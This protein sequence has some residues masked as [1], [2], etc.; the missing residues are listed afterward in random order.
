MFKSGFIGIIGRPNVGKSTL[1]NA[2][3]GEK[4]AIATHKPQTTRNRITGILNIEQGQLV[5]VDTPGIHKAST[6]LNQQMVATAT[7]TFKHADI[8]C[9]LMEADTGLQRDDRLIIDSLKQTGLPIVLVINKIDLI[10]KTKLLPLIDEMRQY[11]DFEAIIPIS[12]LTKDGISD[13]IGELWK[14]LP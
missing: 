9:L 2:A 14:L 6:M 12:A 5:F 3:I 1:L 13:F 10:A 7:D 4:I 8:L 11:Y